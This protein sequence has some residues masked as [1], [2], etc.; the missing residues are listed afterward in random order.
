M[1]PWLGPVRCAGFGPW[2]LPSRP[3]APWP[4]LPREDRLDGCARRRRAYSAVGDASRAARLVRAE[5]LPQLLQR[6]PLRRRHLRCPLPRTEVRFGPPLPHGERVP[7][8]R[9]LTALTASSTDGFVGLL[10]PT[11][12]LEV[13]RVAASRHLRAR[14]RLQGLPSDATPS[15]AF[16]SA[17][18]APASPRE[19]C[20][21]AVRRP[22]TVGST[23]GPCSTGESVASSRRCRLDGPEALLGFPHL[24]PRRDIARLQ[25]ERRSAPA[26]R[27]ATSTARRRSRALRRHRPSARRRPRRQL[28]LAGA[29]VPL[30]LHSRPA[31]AGRGVRSGSE[32][33]ARTLRIFRLLPAVADSR[34]R[35]SRGATSGDHR[36]EALSTP[37][38]R[39]ARLLAQH[40]RD[41]RPRTRAS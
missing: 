20:P 9:F 40:L 1:V 12:D 23:S 13:H 2:S 38:V 25:L 15:R 18:A 4:A 36:A 5:R 37:A 19:L 8:S 7:P 34:G 30:F 33:L 27:H 39:R 28:A 11:A 26:R 29:G 35:P 31:G 41:A 22:A 17:A 16:P 24:E 14:R 3:C 10:H 32:Q 21:L 6:T